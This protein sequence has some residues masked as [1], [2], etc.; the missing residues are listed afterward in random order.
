[1]LFLYDCAFWKILFVR[2]IFF[3]CFFENS[4]NFVVT[5]KMVVNKFSSPNISMYLSCQC[6][7]FSHSF[8][9]HFSSANDFF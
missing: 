2:L 7:N 5:Q 3:H 4:Q 1:M 8:F 6:S 9:F